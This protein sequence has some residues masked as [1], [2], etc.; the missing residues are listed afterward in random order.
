MQK[1]I[2]SFV[3][4][5]HPKY[6]YQAWNLAYSLR[7]HCQASPQDITVHVTP[8]VAE[9]TRQIFRAEGYRVCELTPFGDGRWCNKVVQIPNLLEGK[10]DR[11]VLLDTDMIAVGDFRRFLHGSAVQ[12]KV[13]DEA[14]PPLH[15]LQEIFSVLSDAPVPLMLTDAA[16]QQTIVGN[17]NGGFYSLPGDCAR[18][19][20]AAWKQWALWL[21]WRKELLEDAGQIN[22]VDQI[23]AAMAFRLSGIPFAALPS[24]VNYFLHIRREHHYLDPNLPIFLIHYHDVAMDRDGEIAPPISLTALEAA[25]VT[26]ANQ[27]IRWFSH[28]TLRKAYRDSIQV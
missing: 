18:A 20:H 6:A 24:N 15:V 17:A 22:H 4:D 9:E 11:I 21:L 26:A 16:S 2:Y 23:S 1:I 19:F 3:V 8:G 14:N 25:A 7:L 5:A 27:Q 13:V 12:A 28:E 10:P